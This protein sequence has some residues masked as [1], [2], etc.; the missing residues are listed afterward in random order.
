MNMLRCWIAVAVLA[1]SWM[2][3]LGYFYPADYVSEAVLVAAGIALLYGTMVPLPGKREM[4]IATALLLPAAIW[5]PWPYAIIPIFLLL[6]LLLQLLPI[7]MRWPKPLGQVIIA[8]GGILLIQALAITAYAAQTA[9][10]HEL[11]WPLPDFLAAVA[12]LFSIDAAFDGVNIVF[13]TMRQTHRLAPAW[14]L[15]FDPVS[16]CFLAGGIFFLG[17]KIAADFP[18]GKRWPQWIRSLRIFTIL[19]LVWLPVRAGLLLAIYVHRVL[20]S[21]PERSLYVMNHF[22][23][24]WPLLLYALVPALLAWRFASPRPLEEGPGERAGSDARP[25]PSSFSW[26]YF[27]MLV[28]S[29]GTVATFTMAV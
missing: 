27:A 11:T 8:A 12:R 4:A 3:G 17:L 16:L 2:F 9:R 21:D 15:F 7:P 20:N 10:S 14:E 13:R 6:G 22:F 23:A 24:P 25:Q 28:L 19:F 29:G 18:P 5:A 1:G 26:R